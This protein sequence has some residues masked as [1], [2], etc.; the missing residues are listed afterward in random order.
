MTVTGSRRYLLQAVLCLSVGITGLF[1]CGRLARAQSQATPVG[2]VPSADV[3]ETIAPPVPTSPPSDFAHL[4]GVAE[5]EGSTSGPPSSSRKLS[6]RPMP[7]REARWGC[8]V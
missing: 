2:G 1:G 8:S 6:L 7:G 4:V 5:A 3:A